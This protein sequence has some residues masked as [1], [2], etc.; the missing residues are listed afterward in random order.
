VKETEEVKE[1][2]EL[3]DA[4]VKEVEEGKG[5]PELDDAAKEVEVG[6]AA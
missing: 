4:A 2:P 5:A 6:P 1:A 3:D